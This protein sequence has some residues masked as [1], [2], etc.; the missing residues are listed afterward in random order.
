MGV[1]Q[2]LLHHRPRSRCIWTLEVWSCRS[3]LHCSLWRFSFHPSWR[4]APPVEQQ[5]IRRKNIFS[6]VLSNFYSVMVLGKWCCGNTGIAQNTITASLGLFCPLPGTKCEEPAPVEQLW[7]SLI[8]GILE[9][10]HF[11]VQ[12]EHALV[13]LHHGRHQAVKGKSVQE[14]RESVSGVL[15][16]PLHLQQ[17]ETLHH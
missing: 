1:N 17:S 12:S 15:S 10:R 7:R 11:V 16:Y 13:L 3:S 9:S 5:E 14:S 4:S 2:R 6:V 8:Q